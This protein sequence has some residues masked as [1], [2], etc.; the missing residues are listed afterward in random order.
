MKKAIIILM[1]ILI[2]AAIVYSNWS[3]VINMMLPAD[4][5][6]ERVVYDIESVS[7]PE[8][9]KIAV[10]LSE[11][12]NYDFSHIA[13]FRDSSVMAYEGPQTC[14]RCH[15]V[16]EV[17]DAKTQEAKQVDLMENLTGSSHYLFYTGQHP[18]VYGFN[19]ELADNFDMGKINRPC[20]KPGSFAM[21]AWAAFVVLENGDTLSEGCGQCHI[22]G[23][24]AA[25]LGE[26][27]PGYSTLD[28][29]KETIDCLICHAVAYDMN[30][31]QAVADANSRIRWDQ[32]RS[33]KAAMSVT[34]PKAQA[35]LRCQREK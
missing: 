8:F 27:M 6:P 11:N 24:Y 29:E 21:T 31:K 4:V 17:E 18:N 5:R 25:P 23:Q 34:R 13:T 1:I 16:I 15:A 26:M 35:C 7:A 30:R 20:P 28:I 33:L 10:E 12:Y 14:L 3:T 22:A 19:G 32:D 2:L 9:E